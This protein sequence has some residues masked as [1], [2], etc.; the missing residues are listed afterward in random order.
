MEKKNKRKN[1]YIAPMLYEAGS[2]CIA[3]LF[4]FLLYR[5]KG[6][7]SAVTKLSRILRP[8]IIGFAIAY[9]LT[10]VCRFFERLFARLTGGRL[11]KLQKVA[12]IV[13][14]FAVFILAFYILLSL[15]VPQ[16]Y[17]SILTL[18][19]TL[20]QGL[21]Q[22]QQ[23]IQT[24]LEDRPDLVAQLD[25][26]YST[27]AKNFETWTDQKLLPEL[28]TLV[29]GVGSGVLSVV[30][31]IKDILVGLVVAVYALA[32]RKSIKKDMGLFLYSAVPGKWAD[33][34]VEECKFADRMFSGFL[35]GK[36]LDSLIIG[37]ICYVFCEVTA[38]PSALL[39]ST[40]IG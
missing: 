9:L 16:M 38:M 20:P 1:P 22:L 27:A 35:S 26:V 11:E 29:G 33:V 5:V 23:S 37:I 34:I 3:I 4:F 30:I 31:S 7:G 21:M 28:S 17:Y 32:A 19:N 2:F 13:C 15:I 40:I 14:S 25:T 18:K 10:P 36:A 6:I 12:G 24:H 8:F 39:V